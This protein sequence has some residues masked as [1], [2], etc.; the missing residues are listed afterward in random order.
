MLKLVT[1][2]QFEKD[3]D[4]IIKRGKNKE[5]LFSAMKK[6]LNEEILDES[7]RMGSWFCPIA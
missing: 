6:L 1:T 2:N 3:F 7:C 5:K 4:R